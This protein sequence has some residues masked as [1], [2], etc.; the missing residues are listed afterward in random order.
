MMMKKLLQ[1]AVLPFV[2]FSSGMLL[3]GCDQARE[4][5]DDAAQIEQ[6]SDRASDQTSQDRSSVETEASSR[7]DLKSGNMFYIARDVADMQ[8]KTGDY[9]KKL[10]QT[11]NDL[12]QALD[13]KDQQQLQKT[14]QDL[15]EQLQNFDQALNALNLKS[16][17]VNSIRSE[18]LKANKQMLNSSFLNGDIDL[19]KVNFDKIQKQMNTIQTDMLQLAA[20]LI[21]SSSEEDNQN[22]ADR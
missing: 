7:T 11:Q 20:M 17:E 5:H 21:P 12:Q 6:H 2:I 13:Q 16:Q 4:P 8:L 10:E 18:V 19:S 1:G 9:V 3:L 14:A 22:D 15:R